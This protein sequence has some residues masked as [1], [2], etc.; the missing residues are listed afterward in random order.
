MAGH[1]ARF[2]YYLDRFNA[3]Q[4]K[5]LVEAVVRKVEIESLDR[6]QAAFV[7]PTAPLG[8]YDE[9]RQSGGSKWCPLW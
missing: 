2:G 5:T 1:L 9:D 4:R 6:G 3:G 7:L 8:G